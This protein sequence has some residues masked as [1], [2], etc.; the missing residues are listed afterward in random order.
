MHRKMSYEV[1]VL[2]F[3]SYNLNY[4]AKNE[5]CIKVLNQEVKLKMD[6][7]T[8]WKSQLSKLPTQIRT[9]IQYTMLKYIK[10]GYYMKPPQC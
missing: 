8:D 2:K 1:V 10:W 4:S 5:T 6:Q 7:Q 9:N 3:I